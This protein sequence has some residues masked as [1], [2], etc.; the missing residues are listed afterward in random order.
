MLPVSHQPRTTD[1]EEYHGAVSFLSGLLSILQLL[2][3]TY[4]KSRITPPPCSSYINRL[5]ERG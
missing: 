2:F 1:F 3:Y 5:E 4:R